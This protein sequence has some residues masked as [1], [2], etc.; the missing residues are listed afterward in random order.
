MEIPFILKFFLVMV[1]MILADIAWTYFFIKVDERR[2][3]AAGIWSALIVAFGA[4]TTM[5]YVQDPRLFFAAVIGAFI[6]TAG[7]VKYKQHK[8]KKSSLLK[9]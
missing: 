5:N 3:I 2:A 4:F 8:E 6:G 1:S 9:D 7:T